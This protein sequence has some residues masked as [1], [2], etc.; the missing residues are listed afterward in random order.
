M[1]ECLTQSTRRSA[2]Y[3]NE[4]GAVA[5]GFYDTV[6]IGDA[7]YCIFAE[8]PLTHTVA[9]LYDKIL[10]PL[11]ALIFGLLLST[12]LAIQSIRHLLKK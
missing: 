8:E 10:T 7:H 12:I 1:Q 2:P 11:L 5:V 6:L 9:T 4:Y 3:T